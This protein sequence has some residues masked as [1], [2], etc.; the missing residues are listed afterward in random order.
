MINLSSFIAFHAR[1]T[2][3]RCALRYRGEDISYAEFDTDKKL[4]LAGLFQKALIGP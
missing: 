3:G 1:R 4:T 2:P